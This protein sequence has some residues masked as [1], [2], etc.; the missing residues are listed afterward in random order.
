MIKPTAKKYENN[1]I[2]SCFRLKESGAINTSLFMLSEVVD[3]L[4]K[5]KVSSRLFHLFCSKLM[6]SC[7]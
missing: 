1:V 5:H 2:Y 6:F 3:A 4:N 7:S